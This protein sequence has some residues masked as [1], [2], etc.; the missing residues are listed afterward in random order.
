MQAKSLET[1][2]GT[3]GS[4]GDSFEEEVCLPRLL[5]STAVLNPC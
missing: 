2:Q 4:E 1:K 5:L 3:S